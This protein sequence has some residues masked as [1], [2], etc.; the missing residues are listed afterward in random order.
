MFQKLNNRK[1]RTLFMAF[2]F[3]SVF[4]LFAQISHASTEVYFQ[5]ESK[6][7]TKGD[8]FLADLEISS[9]DT[10]NVIDG[11]ITY[12]K[13]KLEIKEVK[14]NNSLLSLW[15]KEPTFN[16]KTGE[17]SFVGGTPNGF[18]GKDGLIFEITFF[19]KEKGLTS[20]GFKDIFSVFKNDGKGTEINPWLKPMSLSIN[21][22]PELF[23][24]N[25]LDY[26]LNINIYYKYGIGIFAIVLVILIIINK[27]SAKI[28]K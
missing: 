16:N 6:E 4:F 8:T 3:F 7:I 9:E 28:K 27:F 12:D 19:A 17:L 20:V 25:I 23:A 11:T 24:E 14:I 5:K 21:N 15:A 22:P 1:I 26:F 18:D 10:V 2:M 13:D